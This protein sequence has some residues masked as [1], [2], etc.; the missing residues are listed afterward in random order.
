[1]TWT[2]EDNVGLTDMADVGGT[3]D[4]IWTRGAQGILFRRDSPPR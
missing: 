4:L 3:R 1:M 2:T